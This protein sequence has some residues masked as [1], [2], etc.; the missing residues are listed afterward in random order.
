MKGVLRTIAARLTASAP[1][2]SGIGPSRHFAAM[3]NLVASGHSGHRVKPH[4]SSS[5][6]EYAAQCKSRTPF[7][8]ETWIAPAR[9]RV[10][11]R[12]QRSG[13]PRWSLHGYNPRCLSVFH[14]STIPHLT[15]TKLTGLAITVTVTSHR[16]LILWDYR[17]ALS[18]F[19]R[20][21]RTSISEE[22]TSENDPVVF[23]QE[24]IDTAA[25]VLAMS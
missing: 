16:A 12:Q 20:V 18:A 9:D 1:P 10:T 8:R 2:T 22:P 25:D 24:Y 4:Q 5:L 17:W 7:P 23:F 21:K 14:D 15:R 13:L 11:I 3:Q 19:P 6:Y